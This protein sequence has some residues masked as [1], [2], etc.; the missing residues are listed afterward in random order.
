MNDGVGAPQPLGGRAKMKRVL[1]SRIAGLKLGGIVAILLIPM[2]TLSY[3]MICALQDDIKLATRERASTSLVRLLVPV[4]VQASF[5]H[6]NQQAVARLRERGPA[7]AA[8]L[9]LGSKLKS[10]LEATAG[11]AIGRHATLGLLQDLMQANQ[12]TSGIVND[13][14]LE[15]Y[16]LGAAMSHHIR[17]A[18]RDFTDIMALQNDALADGRLSRDEAA[19]IFIAFGSWREALE[20]TADSI[21][22]AVAAAGR[23]KA[24]EPALAALAKL[25]RHAE[26]LRA[27]LVNRLDQDMTAPAPDP[28][29]IADR[30][31]HVGSD[32]EALWMFTVNR[33]EAKVSQR[34]QALTYQLYALI[35][36]AVAACCIG[37]GGAAMMFRSTLRRLDEVEHARQEAE[38]A[39]TEAEAAA[40]A[41]KTVNDDASRLNGELHRNISLLRETQD[42]VLRKGKMAQLGQLTATV[43]HELRN[44]LGA[45][46]T[47]VFLLER[48]LKGKGMSVE[49]QLERINNG[50]TRCDTIISQ[51]L[52]YARNKT[53]S[54]E[55]VVVDDWLAKLVEEEAQKLPAAVAIE[56]TLGLGGLKASIDPSR[57]SR[58]VINL[59]ANAS[60]ALVG[61]GEDASK[62]AA[63]KPQITVA[64][65]QTARGIELSVSDNGPGISPENIDKIFEPLFTTK[66]FGTGLG[67]PAVMKILE[68][69]GGD[70]EVHSDLGQGATFTAWWPIAAEKEEA[71]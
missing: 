57:L 17:D 36:L 7:L 5:G 3:F 4:T 61:K 29:D 40:A 19:A 31:Q 43:A 50:V 54:L 48:K 46:R 14:A 26:D 18:L 69:H 45:V 33:M 27:Q 44:P 30:G 16:Y 64:T 53:L 59:L 60:E 10:V 39:R 15:S 67:L 71:A 55:D 56:C 58:V 9:G 12:F 23:P 70:L 66:N 41:L 25:D 68:Q 65:Q 62:F 63:R 34:L 49:A 51:L 24:Y 42:E 20:R 38:A 22:Q 13:Q 2:L 6:Q 8:S 35:A 21:D 11:N 1:A 32:I 37:V 47:S 28:A 52:D